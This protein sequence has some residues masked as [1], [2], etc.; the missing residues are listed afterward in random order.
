MR[1]PQALPSLAVVAVSSALAVLACARVPTSSSPTAVPAPVA[2]AP[3]PATIAAPP[4]RLRDPADP[5]PTFT[6]P[7]RRA[8]LAAAFPAIEAYLAGTVDRDH[9]VG[10]AAAVV[11]DGEI[12]WFRGWGHRDPARGLPIERDTAFGIG[13]ITK[14]ITTLAILRLRDEG[15]LDLDRPAAEY[16]PELEQIVYP[17]A[18]SPKI[19][20]RQILTH[21]SGLPRMGNFPEYPET[22]PERA[23]F[24]ATLE[25]VG[26]ERAPGEGR[27]Y[28]N[29]AVQL[30]GPLLDAVTGVDH[31]E[32]TRDAILR[33]IGMEGAAWVAED[34]PGDRLAVGHGKGPDGAVHPRP[35]WRPGAADAAGGL[36]A[37]VDDLARYAAYNLDA[38]P[39]RSDPERGPLR[40]ATLR[41]AHTLQ[42]V[43]GL[44]FEGGAEARAAGI[45]GNGLGFG[46]FS[47]CRHDYVVAHAGK[48]LNYRASLHMLPTRGVAVILLSN[49]SSIS[50]KVLPADGVKVLDLLADTGALEPRRHAASDDLLAAA[51]ELGALVGRWDPADHARIFSDDYR[52]GYP[53]FDT[54]RTF[55]EWGALVGECREPRAVDVVEPRAGVVELRCDRGALRLD[56]R[57]APWERR[58]VTTLSFV[59]ATGLEAEPAAQDAAARAL[60]LMDRWDP[61]AH[62]RLFAPSLGAER[63]RG[64]LGEVKAALGRCRLGPPRTFAPRSVTYGLECERGGAAM[65]VRLGDGSPA[66]ITAFEIHKDRGRDACDG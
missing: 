42:R 7:E 40:R 44:R 51:A 66:K 49:H 12:A 13:S 3:E 29:L 52:D 19:T 21:G 35:P 23:E 14:T 32:Y 8:R 24:L 31:R 4:P 47:T 61:R 60:K 20:I 37:S 46:V 30:L 16:L 58:G 9:L 39:P 55:R 26:L 10:L 62:E 45:G 2:I 36:Y 54:E 38:W 25:G 28:S 65:R 63:I 1:S 15:R 11:I 34:V 27:V 17:T 50:S 18:D 5:P 56:L 57:V 53:I 59:G 41:E 22:P 48:T 6:D 33:P 43:A 64:F